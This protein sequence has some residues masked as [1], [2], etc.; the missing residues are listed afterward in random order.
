M[1]CLIFVYY[2]VY[3]DKCQHVLIVAE[4]V[5]IE[6]TLPIRVVQIS[7]LLHYRP[8]HLPYML[9][10]YYSNIYVNCQKVILKYFLY[11]HELFHN[12]DEFHLL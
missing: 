8:A 12:S 1:H 9:C 4:G 6:P 2:T 5:G 3:K 10:V 11:V 7:S